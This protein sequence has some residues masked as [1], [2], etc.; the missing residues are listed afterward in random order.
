[1]E[2]PRTHGS[3]RSGTRRPLKAEIPMRRTRS[4]TS[5]RTALVFPSTSF[6]HGIGFSLQQPQALLLEGLTSVCFILQVS[7]YPR[8][9][10]LPCS[11][12]KRTPV[13]ETAPPP[14]ISVRSTT[15]EWQAHP[16]WQLR[17]SGTS[18]ASSY[19]IPLPGT[20]LAPS[21]RLTLSTPT[22]SPKQSVS[23]AN[24]LRAVMFRPCIHL[25]SCC[26]TILN[27]SKLP[28]KH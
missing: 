25:D 17:K 9:S 1:M 21:S 19:T 13:A 5:T 15:L 24:Q 6:A 2:C 20:I 23:Y 16:T 14:P 26:S 8:T 4:V 7:G 27:W 28:T 18:A 10:T 12:L 22:T 3:P 11:F